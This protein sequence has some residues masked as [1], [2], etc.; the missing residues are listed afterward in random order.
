MRMPQ[1]LTLACAALV[2]AAPLAAQES[3]NVRLEALRLLHA[4]EPLRLHVH[5]VGKLHGTLLQLDTV[6]L[7]LR[8]RR[9]VRNIPVLEIDSIWRRENRRTQGTAVG[10]IVGA[11]AGGFLGA[12]LSPSACHCANPPGGLYAVRGA[13]L[14]MSF[15]AVI[16]TVSGGVALRWERWYP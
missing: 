16:G 9:A 1:R 2:A 3:S 4:G 8:D 15:G 11:V 12:F 7:L 14:G 6:T 5:R 10:M 13:V